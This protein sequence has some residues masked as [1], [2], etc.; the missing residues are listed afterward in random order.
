MPGRILIIDDIATNRI[1]LKVKLASAQYQ[2]LQADSGQA[3]LTLA[4]DMQPDL[5]LMKLA[6]S[7]IGGIEVCRLLKSLPRTAQIPIIMLSDDAGPKAK[8]QALTAGADDVLSKP[9]DE[10][11]LLARI[12]NLLRA[13][14]TTEELHLREGTRR[15]L[16]FAEDIAPFAMAGRIALVARSRATASHWKATL[17]HLVEDRIDV[18]DRDIVMSYHDRSGAPDLFVI[19]TDLDSPSDGLRLLS[20]LRSRAAT[21]HAG[22]VMVSAGDEGGRTAVALDL[23]ANDVVSFGFDAEEIALRLRAQMRRKQQAD[24]L[25]S[26]LRDGLQMAVTDPLTG[27]YNRRYALPHLARVHERAAE[28]GRP[29]AVMLLDL[30]RF[31]RVNDTYGHAAGDAVL[32]EVASRL[33]ADLRSLDLVARI[34]GEEFLI[35]LPDTTHH[36]ARQTAERL[37]RAIHDTPFVLPQ[38]SGELALSISIGVAMN[39][40]DA[41]HDTGIDALIARAD[42]AL[43]DAKAEGRNQVTFSL[44]AA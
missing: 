31:K 5:I 30:D 32:A 12:R 2:V 8:T 1:V 36:E 39:A 18:A 28:T 42:R 3:G 10:L 14:A 17:Q 24:R 16:G 40:G 25:R 7:D 11:T 41:T 13:H 29:F 21:R 9:L 34:G 38:N 33:G 4:A 22:I 27:L 43:Y 20:K 15:A 19:D 6:L 26:T 23:G 44:S 37:R 35:V